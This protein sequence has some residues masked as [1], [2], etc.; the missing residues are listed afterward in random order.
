MATLCCSLLIVL[1]CFLTTHLKL[2]EVFV[3]KPVAELLTL[4]SALGLIAT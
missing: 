3:F 4:S 2:N 1:Y